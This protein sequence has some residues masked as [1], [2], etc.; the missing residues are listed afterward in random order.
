MLARGKRRA[1]LYPVR[2]EEIP[3]VHACDLKRSFF[4]GLD[5]VEDIMEIYTAQVS[6]HVFRRRGGTWSMNTV[7]DPEA[8]ILLESVGVS[9]PGRRV[10]R[11]FCGWKAEPA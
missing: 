9:L 10:Y 3:H 11:S 7:L 5:A 4:Q 8:D 2:S 1:V 6:V